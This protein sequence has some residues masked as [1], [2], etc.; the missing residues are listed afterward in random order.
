M[1]MPRSLQVR[2]GVS[3]GILLTLLWIAAATAT[4][5]M[6]RHEMDRVFDSSLQEAAQRLLPL[7]VVEIVGREEGEGV[8]QR[9]ADLRE[10]DEFLTYVVWDDQ[11]RLLL[12]S[13]EADPALFPAW[14]GPGF[15]TTATHRFYGEDALQGTIRITAAEPLAHRAAAAR[16]IRMGLGLPLLVFM[17]AALL[18]I[19]L[20][21]RSGLS[22]LRRYRDRLAARAPQDLAPVACDDL[23]TEVAPVGRQSMCF[24]RGSS[25]H[26]RLSAPSRP[27]PRTSCGRHWPERSRRRSGC[28]W[29]HKMSPSPR[30]SPRSRPR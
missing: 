23:P 22:P 9:L 2:L 20:T 21:V 30:G 25:R 29:K 16:D 10:H 13:H 5:V 6:L 27:T 19:V 14:D 11:G 3:L 28:R 1:K 4:A 7:A 15:R 26:S 8:T 24:W 17:P 12:Q 18:A